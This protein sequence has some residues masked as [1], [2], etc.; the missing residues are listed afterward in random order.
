MI[1]DTF[2]GAVT[3]LRKA[4]HRQTICRPTIHRNVGQPVV[5][6]LYCW[7][8]VVVDEKSVYEMSV[9]ELSPHLWWCGE[10]SSNDILST[11]N[12]STDNLSTDNS[13]K[14]RSTNYL[15]N[16]L[17]ANCHSRRKA[18]RWNVG[19]WNVTA[20]LWSTYMQLTFKF[21]EHFLNIFSP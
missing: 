15:F 16:I 4:T 1:R 13:P 8:I 17:S 7:P 11:D 10:N 12:S 20:P 6:S 5:F 3:I 14:C 21:L 18:C 19:R 2:D 9:D